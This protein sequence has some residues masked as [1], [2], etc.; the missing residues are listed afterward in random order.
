MIRD[1]LSHTGMLSEAGIHWSQKPF[2]RGRLRHVN[3]R[4][5]DPSELP[6]LEQA[7]WAAPATPRDDSL[8]QNW[9]YGGLAGTCYNH[10]FPP[11]TKSCLFP[12]TR[13]TAVATPSS[14]HRAGVHL[15]TSDGAIRFVA[16]SIDRG[17]WM[18]MGDRNDGQ[19][20]DPL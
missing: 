9:N 8:G 13:V 11:N 7:A 14:H 4:F 5:N 16:D 10:F 20:T 1:G 19:P 6:Q 2:D 15:M 3:M 12:G 17:V 18:A